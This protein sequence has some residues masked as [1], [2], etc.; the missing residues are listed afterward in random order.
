MIIYKKFYLIMKRKKEW[1]VKEIWERV[2]MWI[3]KNIEGKDCVV[4]GMEKIKEGEYICE[5]KKKQE[6]E[7]YEFMNYMEDKVMIMK[8]EMMRIKML[9]WYIEKMK[10]IKV[11]RG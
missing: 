8:R 5:K 3:K 7:K 4:E 11:E 10:M 1:I 9:G 6:W 2:N